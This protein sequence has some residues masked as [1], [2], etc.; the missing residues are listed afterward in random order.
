MQ[1]GRIVLNLR[2]AAQGGEVEEDNGVY[3]MTD[4]SDGA[5]STILKSL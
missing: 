5:F 3:S 4:L 1:A 2:E